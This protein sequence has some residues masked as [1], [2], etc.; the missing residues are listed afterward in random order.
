LRDEFIKPLI[1]LSLV[2]NTAPFLEMG[3]VPQGRLIDAGAGPMGYLE[4]LAGAEALD[5]SGAE[6]D[7]WNEDYFALCLAC[8][9]A[10][11]ATFVPTDVDSKIRGLLWLKTRNVDSLVRMFRAAQRAHRW[12]LDGISKRATELAGV[13]PVSGHDGEMLSVYAGALGSFLRVGAADLAREAEE[14]IVAELERQVVEFRYAAKTAGGELNVL[15]LAASLTH[16]VGDL[17]QGISFWPTSEPY[18]AA[19]ARLGRLAHE[20]KTPFEGAYQIAAAIYRRAMSAEGHRH[21]PLRAVKPL[22]RS[23]DYLLPLGPFFDDWGA[24]IATHPGLALEERAEVMT[25]LVQGCRKIEGQ[26]GYF[27]ALAGFAGAFAGSIDSVLRLMPAGARADWKTTE[28][29][30]QIAIPRSSFESMMMKMARV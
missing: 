8:H 28:V 20:N 11:V 10:T 2:R 13:G 29:R 12:S 30:R 4:V 9:H 22:R 19:R 7:Q 16:N 27:R 25:A 5:G 14:T 3:P 26:K 21:Y 6:G 1:L 15:R 18:R 17:D 24:I 23:P